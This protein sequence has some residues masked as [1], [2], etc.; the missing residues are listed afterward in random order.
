[1]GQI[2]PGQLSRWFEAYGTSLV[3]YARQW[4]EAGQAEDAVQD[5]FV[6][7]ISQPQ[8]PHSAKAW[9]FRSVRNAAISRLRSRRR[10]QA[11]RRRL[12]GDRPGWFDPRPDDLLDGEA[13]QAALASLP[14]AQREAIVLRIWANLTLREIADVTGKPISTVFSRY[15]AGLAALRQRMETP[16]RKSN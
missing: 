10:R 9:L 1:M 8:A 5:V 14:A 15:R 2:E 6:R 13:V 16:C 7:L 11:R 3:L 4:L 12:A